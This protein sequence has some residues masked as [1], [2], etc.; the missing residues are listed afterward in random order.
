MSLSYYG[1]GELVVSLSDER[2]CVAVPG[3]ED[4]LVSGVGTAS[5]RCVDGEED[6]GA[7]DYACWEGR[8]NCP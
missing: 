4:E 3:L 5:A 8:G 1:E 2:Y 7:I 6:A